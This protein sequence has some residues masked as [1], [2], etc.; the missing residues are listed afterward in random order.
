MLSLPLLKKEIKSNI[1]IFI[2][3]LFVL[4]FYSYV[5]ITMFNP[6]LGELLEGFSKS[7]PQLMA[8]FGMTN[9]GTTLLAFLITYFYGFFALIF[10]LVF[11]IMLTNRLISKYVDNGSMAYLLASP[12]SRKRIVLTQ[13]LCI[14]LFLALMILVVFCVGVLA[15]HFLFPNALDIKNYFLANLNVLAIQFAISGICFFIACFMQDAKRAMSISIGVPVGFYLLQ[16]VANLGGNMENFK[17][18]TLYTLYNPADLIAGKTSAMI[19]MLLLF[20][21]G[22]CFYT[23]AY[24]AFNKRDLNV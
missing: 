21:I 5:I 4:N 14:W 7:M 23:L 8:A 3:I 11:I 16:M 9:P 15:S 13:M 12:N 20:A 24:H 10:P 17:Y 22:I 18:V 19:S 6:K 1:K 2:I